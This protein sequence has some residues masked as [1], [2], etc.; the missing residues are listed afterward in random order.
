MPIQRNQDTFTFTGGIYDPI[1]VTQRNHNCPYI[2]GTDF[3]DYLREVTK[4]QHTLGLAPA[5][6]SAPQ[7]TP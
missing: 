7:T 6:T 4:S 1:L 2:V 3:E 5:P